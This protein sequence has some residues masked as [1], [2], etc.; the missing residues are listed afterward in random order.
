[1]SRRNILIALGVVILGGAL[2][3]AN[4]WYKKETGLTVTTEVVKT[5]P[6]YALQM[7]PDDVLRSTGLVTQPVGT[8]KIPWGKRYAEY[9]RPLLKLVPPDQAP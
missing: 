2:V 3:A 1:M 9:D 5:R 6:V 8:I 4:L 7:F